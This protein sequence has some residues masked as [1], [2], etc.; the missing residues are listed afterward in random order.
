MGYTY[1]EKKW[2]GSFCQGMKSLQKLVVQRIPLGLGTISSQ[3]IRGQPCASGDPGVPGVSC[4]GG[5]CS[6]PPASRLWMLI[7]AGEAQALQNE[8]IS[9]R[10]ESA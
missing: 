1:Q 10:R 3:K 2:K 4:P 9:S 5:S 6:F 8:K 7:P